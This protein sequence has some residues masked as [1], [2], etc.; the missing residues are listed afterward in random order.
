VLGRF[1]QAQDY[2]SDTRTLIHDPS[3]S[4]YSDTQILGF[5]NKAR[6]RVAEDCRCVR[7]MLT[8]LNTITQQ[9]QYPLTD[10]VGGLALTAPGVN[11]TNPTLAF[12][13]G[14][15][16]GVAGAVTQLNGALTGPYVTN[17]GS[18]YTSAPAVTISDPTGSGGAI[19]A[20][21]GTSILD[22][23]GITILQSFPASSATLAPALGWLPWDAFQAFCRAYRATYSWPGAW[24]AHYGPT[25][26]LQQTSMQQTVYLYPIPN[27]VMPM[28]WDAITLPNVLATTVA[29]DYQVVPP[30]TDAVQF[31][32]AHYA[33]LGLQQWAAAK[34]MLDLYMARTREL[35][36]TARARRVHSFY[37]MYQS[38][39]RRMR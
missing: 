16:T 3:A 34:A 28:E 21:N 15:G 19:S 20:I 26:P 12:S 25:T 4:D 27:Q 30:W 24:T 13:G 9:E 18:T 17:W 1:Y 39:I 6:Y 14:G 33:Y 31:Y 2:I 35:P 11:Y 36:S 22:L 8:G 38:T 7:Q 5:V 32:A 10:F 29:V 23:Y 37:R